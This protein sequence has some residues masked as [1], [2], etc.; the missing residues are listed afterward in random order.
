M[1]T[2]DQGTYNLVSRPVVLVAVPGAKVEEL[3]L[4]ELVRR[5]PDL[6][7]IVGEVPSQAFAMLRFVLAVVH[8]AIGGPRTV[9]DWQYW[10]EDWSRVVG[11]VDEYLDAFEERFDLR[12]AVAPFLQ[13][14]DLRSA[15]GEVFGL[16]RLIADVPTGSPFMTTRLGRSIA[17][18]TWA[19]AAR[20]LIHALAADPSG[21]KT[22]AV[23]DP[24]VKGGKGYPEGTGWLGQIGS[25]FLEGET[26]AETLMLNLVAYN[27]TEFTLES[28]EYDVPV[29]ERPPLTERVDESNHGQPRGFIDLYVWPSRRIRLVGDGGGVTGVV[30]SYGDKMTPQNRQHFEPMTAWRYSDPQTKKLGH[31]TY[32]PRTHNPDRALWRGIAALLPSVVAP[33]SRSGVPSSLPPAVLAWSATLQ[34]QD[35]LDLPSVR[36][37]AIGVAYGS[38]QS[39][40]AEIVDDTLELPATVLDNQELAGAVVDAVRLADEAAYLLGTLAQNLAYASGASGDAVESP[41]DRIKELAYGR[42]GEVFREWL[43]SL[44]GADDVPE[45]LLAHW[46]AQLRDVAKTLAADAISGVSAGAWRGHDRQGRRI[47]VGIADVWFHQGLSKLLPSS[48]DDAPAPSDNKEVPA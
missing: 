2:H 46:R 3:S 32:M 47:D 36:L 5:A 48:R 17:R 7:A 18:I 28:G 22:G 8:R 11:A 12:S 6:T 38:Q 41:R 43:R 37:R 42:F 34:R 27:V 16:E 31:D 25:I 20:W 24:R 40:Y 35:L 30:L 1:T 39:T 44:V 15:K 21:I 19:E 33:S 14:P 29:W 45:D 23:G 26:L 9:E 4:R 13:V 10:R